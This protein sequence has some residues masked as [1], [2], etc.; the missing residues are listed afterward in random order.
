MTDLEIVL[1]QISDSTPS[2][3]LVIVQPNDPLQTCRICRYEFRASVTLLGKKIPCAHCGALVEVVA[4]DKQ[5]EDPLIGKK[6][7]NCRLSY[8]LGAGGIGLVYAGNQLSVGRNVAIK[9]LGAKA[10]ANEVLVQRFQ[11]EAKLSAQINHPG[12]VQVYDY[13]FDRGVHYQIMELVE[14]GT[15]AQLIETQKRLPWKEVLDIGQQL[16]AALVHLH[17]NDI[18]HRDIKPANVLIT[19]EN[20][21]RKA[22]LADLGLAKQLDEEQTVSGLTMEGKPLGSPAYMP[23]EQVRNAKDATRAS[24]IYGL[25]ATLY[26]AITGARPFDGKTSYEVMA[27]VLTKTATPPITVVPDIPAQL[28]ELI[29]RCLSKDV[30]QRPANAESVEKSLSDLIAV[31]GKPDIVSVTAPTP[32]WKR[33]SAAGASAATLSAD[34]E[35]FTPPTLQHGGKH[36]LSINEARGA[37]APSSANTSPSATWKRPTSQANAPA[38]EPHA[39]APHA[40]MPGWAIGVMIGMGVVIIALLVVIAL[41]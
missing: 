17:N 8:R 6:I 24:D 9:M 12:V 3:G 20:G 25:G 1:S 29:I 10:G 34:S 28:N 4:A 30:A 15:L 7:G 37:V 36:S 14:G 23:P 35:H 33:P 13:G 21:R 31:H 2:S 40:V 41:K 16:A 38:S 19:L 5:K 27:H 26:A 32:A 22:K 39:R 11:R 18:I